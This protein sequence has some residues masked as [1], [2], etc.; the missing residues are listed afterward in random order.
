[1]PSNN[2]TPRVFVVCLACYNDGTSNGSWQDA[3]SA[4]NIRE[5]ITAL[6]LECGHVDNDWAI[7]DYDG[8]PSGL[9]ENPDLDKLEE[10]ALLLEEHG[11]AYRAYMDNVG[12][13]YATADGFEEAYVG[14][15]A[16]EVD[17][18]YHIV[19]ECG[20]LDG[21]SDTMQYYFDYEAYARDLFLDGHS[22]VNGYVFRDC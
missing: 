4:D 17:Y 5:Y 21:I 3:T 11:D 13:H 10:L 18:A 9:G 7:H 2:Y 15:F 20:M 1:M 19:D 16:N 14:E 12:G 8:I 22:F 6:Q